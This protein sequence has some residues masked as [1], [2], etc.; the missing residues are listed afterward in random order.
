MQSHLGQNMPVDVNP[1]TMPRQQNYYFK[2]PMRQTAVSGQGPV[3]LLNPAQ[4]N[5]SV[6]DPNMAQ[7]SNYMQAMAMQQ[8]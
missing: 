2:P 7:Q 6:E 4:I 1:A 5:F 8:Q 3:R